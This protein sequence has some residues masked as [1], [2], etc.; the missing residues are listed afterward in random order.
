MTGLVRRWTEDDLPAVREV[1]RRSWESA[2]ASFI[3]LEDLRSYLDEHYSLDGLRRL[4]ADP[5]VTGFVGVVG[6][7]VVAMMRLKNDRDESRT[8]VS[9]IYVLPEQQGNGWGRRLMRVAAEQANIAGRTELWLGVMTQNIQALAWYRSHGFIA[10]RE[11]PF[12]M[13]R[14]AVAHLIG[15]LPV[16]SFLTA[17]TSGHPPEA[18]R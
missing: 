3:P 2:Y 9:S 8:Y 10:V 11:E 7:R 17:S 16:S 12:T 13:G 15:R 5:D 1:L 4:T 14:T 18:Q 6:D